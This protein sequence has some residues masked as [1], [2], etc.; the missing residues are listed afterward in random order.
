VLHM[1]ASP[2]RANKGVR[3]VARLLVKS[4]QLSVFTV[5]NRTKA[6]GRIDEEYIFVD[7]GSSLTL[8]KY[9]R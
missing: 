8:P 6:K 5:R 9:A 4:P 7:L 1:T 3:L 2:R